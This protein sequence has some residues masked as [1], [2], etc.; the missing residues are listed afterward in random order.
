MAERSDQLSRRG[1][2]LVTLSAVLL[3]KVRSCVWYSTMYRFFVLPPGALR[4]CH[5]R[6]PITIT[7]C[8]KHGTG[9]VATL[10]II[11]GKIARWSARWSRGDLCYV[12]YCESEPIAH[13]WLCLGE[14]RLQDDD[15]GR[16][17]PRHGVFLYDARTREEWRGRRVYQALV[18]RAIKD[19]TMQGYD[20]VYAIAEECSVPAVRALSRLG[21]RRTAATIRA[22]RLLRVFRY[23]REDTGA[24]DCPAV[25]DMVPLCEYR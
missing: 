14:W 16:P 15:R 19:V 25:S 3:R 8:N 11:K 2:R 23:R 17:L 22:C 1:C 18:S 6:A 4:E 7:R 13:I 20:Y 21:F 10:K 12:A 5:P 9:A 24:L